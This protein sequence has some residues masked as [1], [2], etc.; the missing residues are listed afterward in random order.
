[1]LLT[2]NIFQSFLIGICIGSFLN[3]V[4]YRL[5]VGLSIIKPRSFCPK[6]KNKIPWSSNIPLLSFLFQK[7]KCSFC[8]SKIS[9]QY[10]LIEIITGVLFIIFSFSSSYFYSF[11]LF[12]P[13]ENLFNW[14]FLSILIVISFI[15]IEHFW[16]P[17]S[18]INFGYVTGLINLLFVEFFKNELFN[19][20]ILLKGISGSIG[21]YIIFEFLRFASKLYFKKEAL[22]KGD[23]KLVSMLGLWLGPV[24]VVLGI[25][26]AYVIAAIFL[27]FAFKAKKIKK[28][29]II[30]F[31]PFL[32][33]G[34]LLV[35]LFGNYSLVNL[36]YSL[37]L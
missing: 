11:T 2:I 27:L 4:I 15:D 6:C 7:G 1:M 9:F 24:G 37:Q 32:S 22:G 23:S 12:V 18:L 8:N 31:A 36:I 21:A 19:E 33:C 14:T 35:W 25:G 16:I 13:F 28:G 10:P 29:S 30:P 20:S 3:V 26:I 5:P 34:G 17:Q